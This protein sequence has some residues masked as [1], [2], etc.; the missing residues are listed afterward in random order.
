VRQQFVRRAARRDTEAL[1][2]RARNVGG[3]V[4]YEEHLDISVIEILQQESV[5]VRFAADWTVQINT[6]F[7]GK[8]AMWH[9]FEVA[10]IA[11]LVIFR[12]GGTFVR[13]KVALLQ[14]K[15]LYPDSVEPETEQETRERYMHG[16]G[17]LFEPDSD[18]SALVEERVITFDKASRY[19]ALRGDGRQRHVID[20]YERS[21]EIPVYYLLYNPS[22]LPHTVNV[23]VSVEHPSLDCQVGVR[24]IPSTN[25]RSL[26]Q[27]MAGSPSF[28]DIERLPSPFIG[29]DAAGWRLEKFVVDLLLQCKVGRITDVR[30]DEGLYRVFY[31][32]SGP[33][34]AAVSV[35]L[36][37][38][39]GFDWAVEP[40]ERAT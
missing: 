19:K 14:S 17:G 20:E 22:V 18:L 21:T 5:P 13:S 33:I 25:M 39:D 32:R 31:R 10:D 37:A 29:E 36:D 28:A 30:N 11:L 6:H 16:F 15:R 7:L 27:T 1:R 34:A 3:E 40:E 2:L 9:N 24:V 26:L 35:T 12:S 8:T 4:G 23:P 38:P